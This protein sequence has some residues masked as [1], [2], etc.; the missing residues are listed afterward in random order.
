MKMSPCCHRGVDIESHTK[1]NGHQAGS[2][3]WKKQINLYSAALATGYADQPQ[4]A[5]AEQ[6]DSGRNRYHTT[7]IGGDV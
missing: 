4:Q 2:R 1:K 3:F 6:P 7:T 5:G